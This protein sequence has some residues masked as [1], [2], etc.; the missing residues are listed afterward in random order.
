MESEY[1][2]MALEL[3]LPGLA[4]WLL[5]IA[6]VLTRT[7]G[8]VRDSWLLGRRMAFATTTMTFA[9]GLI[10]IGMLT[11]V[12]QTI[13]MLLS[14]GWFTVAKRPAHV[15]AERRAPGEPMRAV[16]R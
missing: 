6:W 8:R 2:R 15:L 12:P 4:L 7:P 16:A 13:L 9:S 3:G 1:A 10:G 5:F 11:S 14:I